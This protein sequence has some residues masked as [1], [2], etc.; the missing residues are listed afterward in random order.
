MP[1][2]NRSGNGSMQRQ[3]QGNMRFQS[4]PSGAAGNGGTERREEPSPIVN[5]AK[6]IR[7]EQGESGLRDFLAAMEP[8]AAPNELRSMA[9]RYGLDYQEITAKRNERRQREQAG[10][11]AFGQGQGMNGFSGMGGGPGG[12]GGFPGMGG[13]NPQLFQM[14]QLMQLMNGM[15]GFSGNPGNPGNSGGAGSGAKSPEGKQ[16]PD[17]M[18]LMRMMQMMPMLSSFMGGSPQG[19]PDLSALM[20]M[21]GR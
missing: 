16:G 10:Q 5:M 3:R 21:M 13:M 2:G 19:M 4:A 11:N 15:N 18:Q 1:T 14:M 20:K 9:E 12:M 8:F 6:R 17:L 7:D